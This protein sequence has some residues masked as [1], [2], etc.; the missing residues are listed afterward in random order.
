MEKKALFAASRSFIQANTKYRHFLAAESEVH[1]TDFNHFF[2]TSESVYLALWYSLLFNVCAFLKNQG[3]VP[4]VIREDLDSIYE[5]FKEFRHFTF[6]RIILMIVSIFCL[7][8]DLLKK[9]SEFMSRSQN[10]LT[11]NLKVMRMNRNLYPIKH[12]ILSVDH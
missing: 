3:A 9:S 8:L 12:N 2:T 6:L 1:P 7:I 11:P 10:Y 4:L 5:S